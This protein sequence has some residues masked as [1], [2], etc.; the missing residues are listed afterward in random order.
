MEKF[1]QDENDKEIPPPIDKHGTVFW[2]TFL[3]GINK[4]FKE[5]CFGISTVP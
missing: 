5:K 4:P 2:I 3:I 1:D